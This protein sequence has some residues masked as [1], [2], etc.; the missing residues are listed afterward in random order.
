M[1]G[2]PES[3]LNNNFARPGVP[4][5]GPGIL[6]HHLFISHSILFNLDMIFI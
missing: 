3:R 4:V 5:G 2:N 1:L 6:F